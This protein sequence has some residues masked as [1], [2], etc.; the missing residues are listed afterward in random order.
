MTAAAP[1]KK[2]NGEAAIRPYRMGTS[3]G[4]RVTACSSRISSGSVR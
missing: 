3:S 4:I 1:R 2:A